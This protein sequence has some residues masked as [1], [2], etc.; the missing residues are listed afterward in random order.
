MDAGGAA[1]RLGGTL[2]PATLKA[3]TATPMQRFTV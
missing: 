2:H 1:G 3:A